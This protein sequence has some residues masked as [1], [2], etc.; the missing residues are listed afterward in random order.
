MAL[1]KM[2]EG[3]SKRKLL[4]VAFI[5]AFPPVIW[6]QLLSFYIDF[7]LYSIVVIAL[8]S[9]VLYKEDKVKFLLVFICLLAI[10]V[11]VKFNM[12][13][14]F[15]LLYLGF[16]A[17]FWRQGLRSMVSYIFV[18]GIVGVIMSGLTF[19]FNPYITNT[20]DHQTPFYPLMGGA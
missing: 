18:Y 6:N 1:E 11:S 3:W 4:L 2:F 16:M 17:Y 12:W 15:G 19:S 7:N 20:I 10:A 5:V 8:C 13:L 9:M 14:W